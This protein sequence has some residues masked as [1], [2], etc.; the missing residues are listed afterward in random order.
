MVIE[1]H[2]IQNEKYSSWNTWENRGLAKVQLNWPHKENYEFLNAWSAN[3][4]F[5]ER[6]LYR[7]S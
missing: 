1:N 6:P 4:N 5:Y 3:E 2:D 7:L